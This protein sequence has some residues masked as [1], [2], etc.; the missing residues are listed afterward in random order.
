MDGNGG[1]IFFIPGAGDGAG[2]N[3]LV[4]LNLPTVDPEVAGAL[5]ADSL[6]VKVSA[7]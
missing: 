5:W 2:R 4:F 7:G 1:D 6:V 3:G